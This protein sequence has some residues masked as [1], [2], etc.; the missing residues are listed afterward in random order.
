VA[1]V[2][3][4][5]SV[6][7]YD[8]LPK[9]DRLVDVPVCLPG[10]DRPRWLSDPGLDEESGL[11]YA[12]AAGLEKAKPLA[13]DTTEDVDWALGVF[14][15]ELFVN[16]NFAEQADFAHALG[17][18]LLPFV[19][20]LIKGST[21]LHAVLAP[22]YGAGKTWLSQAALY[23]GCGLVPATPQTKNEEEWRKRIT[24]SLIGGSSAVL[25]DNFSGTLDSGPL[26]AALTSDVWQDRLLGVS[27]EVTLPIRNVWVITG[28]NLDLADEQVRRAVPLFLKPG[29]ITR[30][31]PQA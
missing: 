30:V 19:R 14:R 10:P 25:L 3:L 7:E 23:P 17:L 4:E 8:A 21:P 27:K 13:A 12:P 29:D 31:G 1:S 20:E 18:L 5:R 9:V 15:N 16:F 2:V 26:A 28:N 24:S 11:Y 22:D 6:D